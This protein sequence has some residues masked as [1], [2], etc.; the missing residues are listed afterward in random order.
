MTLTTAGKDYIA[1]HFGSGTPKCFASSG[2]SYTDPTGTSHTGSTQ[3]CVASLKLAAGSAKGPGGETFYDIPGFQSINDSDVA[4]IGTH[5]SG[6]EQYCVAGTTPPP[7]PTC[8]PGTRR[9]RNSTTIEQCNSSGTGWYDVQTCGTGYTCQNGVCVEP[10]A[11]PETGPLQVTIV[12]G[13]QCSPGSPTVLLTLDTPGDEAFA[14][15]KTTPRLY[16]G[17]MNIFV[18]NLNMGN[19]CYGYFVWEMRMW[20]GA[21]G[22]TCPT[23]LPDWQQISRYIG[24]SPEAKAISPK[25]LGTGEKQMIGGSF[26]IPSTFRGTYTICLSLWGNFDKQALLDELAVAGYAEEIAWDAVK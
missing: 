2:I 13:E 4:W 5:Q 15:F 25:L 22:T 1:S 20:E 16:V 12:E 9:C 8:T 19:S 3:D 14:Y 7:S 24:E 26:E 18:T 17:V 10:T 23:T 21:A 11:R 6:S